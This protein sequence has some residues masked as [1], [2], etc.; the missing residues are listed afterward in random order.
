MPFAGR[1]SKGGRS[2]WK[3]YVRIAEKLILKVKENELI[4]DVDWLVSAIEW[5]TKEEFVT[6]A[7][8]VGIENTDMA[9]RKILYFKRQKDARKACGSQ[10]TPG[11]SS[12][13]S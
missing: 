13:D 1:K 12:T 9:V 4:F 6:G 2:P 10:G 3:K 8:I 7:L 5:I 11:T